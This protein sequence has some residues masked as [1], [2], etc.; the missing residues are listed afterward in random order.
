MTMP[1][2]GR[3]I[4][5]RLGMAASAATASG[6][7]DHFTNSF[8]IFVRQRPQLVIGAVLDR[9]RDE[10]QGRVGVQR[11]GL[12]LGTLNGLPRRHAYRWRLK[13][14][15]VM[16]TAR[17]ARPSVAQPFDDEIDFGGNLLPQGQWRHP[18]VGRL[19]IVLERDTAL[20]EPF[21]QSLQGHVPA[22]LGDV[23]NADG[24]P[25]EL[26]GPCQPRLDVFG[27]ATRP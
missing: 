25:V 16:R 21:A 10:H 24:Q 5:C 20:A 2:D 26:F 27:P 9:M 11:L 23:E 17:Y 7:P 15:H 14:R 12:R 22:R 8:E 13:V 3:L 18:R 6:P 1:A 4:F 19:G